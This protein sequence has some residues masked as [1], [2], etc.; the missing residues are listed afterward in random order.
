MIWK[1]KNH[2]LMVVVA[3]CRVWRIDDWDRVWSRDQW[4]RFILINL[5]IYKVLVVYKVEQTNSWDS[6][7]ADGK[8]R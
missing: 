2:V 5:K 1:V 6:F 7:L 8:M 4:P 3:L